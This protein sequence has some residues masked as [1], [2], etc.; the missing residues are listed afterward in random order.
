MG[1]ISISNGVRSNLMALQSTT[2]M[3]EETQ[4][5]LAT[6]KRVNSALDNPANFFTASAMNDRASDLGSLLDSMNTGVNTIKAADNALTSITKLVESAQGTARQA[7]Q[8]ATGEKEASIIGGTAL[9]TSTDKTGAESELLAGGLG[10][11]VGDSIT[12]KSSKD[13]VDSSTTVTIGATTT[14][15]DLVDG[16]NSGLTDKVEAEVTADGK[17]SITAKDG[18]SLDLSVTDADDGASD[19]TLQDLFG[20]TATVN[21][22]ADTAVQAS[23][24]ADIDALI[25]AVTDAQTAKAAADVTDAATDETALANTAGLTDATAL[26]ATAAVDSAAYD[27]ALAAA[28]AYAAANGGARDAGL[29]ATRDSTLVTRDASIVSRDSAIADDTAATSAQADADAAT[30]AG[31]AVTTAQQALTDGVA[32]DATS[33][34]VSISAPT[35]DANGTREKLAAQ[36]NELLTQITDLAEDADFNGINL[37]KGDDLKVTFN[38][39]TG[40]DENSLTIKGVTLDASGLGLDKVTGDFQS[41]TDIE[42]S[43]GQIKDSLTTLRQQASEFGSSLSVVE[44]RQ[45]FTKMMVDT[46]EKGASDLTLADV[47]KEGAKMLALQ[48]SQQLA[49][50]T[51]GIA[52]RND[53]AILSFLR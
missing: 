46:L 20:T 28:D 1:D 19:N 29:D 2:R 40:S 18:A 33:E 14:V 21:G 27:T 8:D 4:D 41:D 47:N 51:M 49:T 52:N 9:G 36:F 45:D 5:R 3:I 11:D 31:V 23:A 15:K 6:G 53:Q 37:L 25:T 30:A 38:E 10:F 44:T 16:I 39:K 13:G 7:L 22:T 48:T 42:S 50:T 34:A 43:L 32:S 26:T 12:I 35:T 17:L 24:G